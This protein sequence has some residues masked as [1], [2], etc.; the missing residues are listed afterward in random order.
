MKGSTPAESHR[1]LVN[2]E[3]CRDDGKRN[4]RKANHPSRSV[5][6]GRGRVHPP[7][8]TRKK[9]CPIATSS[10]LLERPGKG[11]RA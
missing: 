8:R 3:D 1:S 6:V 4:E 7:G 5:R 11:R 10:S 9:G 2:Q